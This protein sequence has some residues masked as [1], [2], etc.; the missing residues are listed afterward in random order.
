MAQVPW[1]F[2]LPEIAIDVAGCPQIV[3]I[4][5]VQNAVAEFLRESKILKATLPAINLVANTGTY[6]LTTPAGFTLVGCSEVRANGDR[7]DPTSKLK[8]PNWATET[9]TP[10]AYIQ[11]QPYSIDLVKIPDTDATGGL[12]VETFVSIDKATATGLEQ[13]LFEQY[14]EPIA[15]GA[16]ARLMLQA[17]R[18]W[19]NAELGAFHRS[20]FDTAIA[21]A[22]LA[23]AQGQNGVPLRTTGYYR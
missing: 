19:S 10:V 13:W 18:P 14:L 9:G 15:A 23:R 1:T 21:D 12:V 20:T 3:M 22:A 2:F 7:L 4:N 16:K 11:E 6:A 17:G 8:S 5:A